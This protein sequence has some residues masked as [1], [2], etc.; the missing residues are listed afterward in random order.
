MKRADGLAK[1]TL[2]GRKTVSRYRDAEGR[3][4]ADAIHLADEPPP[5]RML[6]PRDPMRRLPLAAWRPEPLLR[7]VLA[8]GRLVEPL[9]DVAAAAAHARARLAQLPPEHR[10]FENPQLYEVGVSPRL[11]DLRA[12]LLRPWLE[13]EAS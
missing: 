5:D 9:P 2:P 3:L 11:A 12:E 8:D 4:R 13:T 1:Q 6:D 7:P 10:R